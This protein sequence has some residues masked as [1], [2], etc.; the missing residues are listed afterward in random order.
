[1]GA[2]HRLLVQ[3]RPAELTSGGMPGTSG[4]EDGDAG[5]FYAPAFPGHHGHFGV[6]KPPPPTVP[7]I[8]HAG[9]LAYTEQKAPCHCTVRQGSGAI[10]AAVSGGGF[11]GEH[12]E[13]L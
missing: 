11:E 12:G 8:Q 6:G 1:M 13:V 3:G 7:P 10:E 9:P 2:L 5:S 4:N